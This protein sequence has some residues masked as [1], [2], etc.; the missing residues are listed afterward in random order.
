MR[1]LRARILSICVA[2]TRVHLPCR[3]TLHTTM[4]DGLRDVNDDAM[5]ASPSFGGL[6]LRS[7]TCKS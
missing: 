1:Q 5:T 3:I 6:Y 2:V 7:S 4:T